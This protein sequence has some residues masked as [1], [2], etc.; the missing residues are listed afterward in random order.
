MSFL[1]TANPEI[2]RTFSYGCN[3]VSDWAT[4]G[5]YKVWGSFS[6]QS[7]N[8]ATLSGSISEF[9]PL[10]WTSGCC[11]PLAGVLTLAQGPASSEVSFTSPCGS[12]TL[13][14]I[15]TLVPLTLPACPN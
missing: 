8:E 12:Y 6:F 13:S 1:D 14:G 3:L 4:A 2:S 15:Q 7:G 9:S 5:S 11:Y 10:A